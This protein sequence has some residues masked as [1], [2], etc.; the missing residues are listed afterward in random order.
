MKSRGRCSLSAQQYA[1]DPRFFSLS[2]SKASQMASKLYLE[3][4]QIMLVI[5][6]DSRIKLNTINHENIDSKL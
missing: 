1:A 3:G 6:I 5:N 4:L 2:I